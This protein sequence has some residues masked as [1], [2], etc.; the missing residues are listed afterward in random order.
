MY[1]QWVKWLRHAKPLTHKVYHIGN[2]AKDR[3]QDT[4]LDKL[5]S[6]FYAL[7][8]LGHVVLYQKR[9]EHHMNYFIVPCYRASEEKVIRDDNGTILEARWVYGPLSYFRGSRGFE[10]GCI[11]EAEALLGMPISDQKGYTL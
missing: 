7:S 10:H 2:L 8:D 11:A 5:A 4:E 6:V 1:E 3:L 9:I